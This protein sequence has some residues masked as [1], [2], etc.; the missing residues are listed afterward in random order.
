MPRPGQILENPITGETFRWLVSSDDTGGELSRFKMCARP[1]GGVRWMHVHP[2]AE[3][4]FEIVSGRCAVRLGRDRFVLEA[5]DVAVLPAGIPHAWHNPDDEDEL[6]FVV[7]VTP[8]GNFE[9]AIETV[10]GL[11]G[12]GRLRRNG[13]PGPLQAAVMAVDLGL[14]V[15]PT[16]PPLPIIKAGIALL[17]PIGRML[18]VRATYERFATPAEATPAV[19]AAGVRAPELALAA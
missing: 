14:E 9:A 7:D 6:H 15:H 8:P 3:E 17:A 10:C 18:G 2:E 19:A 16:H 13:M 1:G 5:G 11:A 12:E 4:R